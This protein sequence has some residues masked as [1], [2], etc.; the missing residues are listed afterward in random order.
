[1]STSTVLT[2]SVIKQVTGGSVTFTAR[3]TSTA[4]SITGNV[5][6]YD[7]TNQI[8][9]A[10]LSGGN[11]QI[12]LNSLTVGTPSVSAKYSG[13][14]QNSPSTSGLLNQLITGSLQFSI[15]ATAGAQTRTIVMNV[16]LE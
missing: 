14:S 3:V 4:S 10:A 9:Q 2:S 12:T 5:T 8:G 1:V 16:L 6:F 15:T 11:S 7:G 13:D